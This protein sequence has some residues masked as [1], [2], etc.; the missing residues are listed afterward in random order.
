MVAIAI[1]AAAVATLP[2]IV[3]AAFV[4]AVVF[5]GAVALGH[6]HNIKNS[7]KNFLL[8]LAFFVQLC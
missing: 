4:A 3:I 1:A 2:V 6:D 8:M 7:N 5:L